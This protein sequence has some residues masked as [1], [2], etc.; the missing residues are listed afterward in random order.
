MVALQQAMGHKKGLVM[1]GRDIGTAVFPN[2]ELKLFMTASPEIRVQRRFEE[3]TSKGVA[4]TLAEIRTNLHQRDH[5]DTHRAE[6]PL[7][8]AADAVV[9]DNS[10]LT[11]QEQLALALDLAR[12]KIGVS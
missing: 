10:T 1:D 11:E 4:V 6:S 12:G 5:D 2:A 7:T 9:I 3:L 8:Q